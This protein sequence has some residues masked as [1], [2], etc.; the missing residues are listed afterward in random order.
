MSAKYKFFYCYI[1]SQNRYRYT[2]HGREANKTLD[3]LL[4]PAIDEIPS[5]VNKLA[6]PES[7]N[8]SPA[9]KKNVSLQDRK[10]KLFR[11]NE[12]FDVKYGVN[13]ELNKLEPIS[14][15]VP[16]V[17]RTSKNNGVSSHV[18]LVENI[19]PNPPGTISVSGGGSVLEC[20]LQDKPYYSGRDLYFLKPAISMSKLSLLFISTVI[21]KEKYRFSYGRQANKTLKSLL[22][23]L[24][25]DNVGSPDWQFMDYYIKS[26]PYSINLSNSP[27]DG[28]FDHKATAKGFNN[29]D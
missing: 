18:K 19:T 9:H 12:L 15:G 16:F 10:W 7:P 2:T 8:S 20:F 5:W 23:N 1:I 28:V 3:N 22:I 4:V 21:G 11:V 14:G 13:L 29:S 17:S 24:P 6:I 25:I 27:E 26:L